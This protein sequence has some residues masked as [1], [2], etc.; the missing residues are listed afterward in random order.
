MT[1]VYTSEHLIVVCQAAQ[2]EANQT[3]R[4]LQEVTP[5]C[6]SPVLGRNLPQA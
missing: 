4:D 3:G 1:V 6:T 2:F 5:L